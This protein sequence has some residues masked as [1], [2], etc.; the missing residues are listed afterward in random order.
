MNV[1]EYANLKG[2]WLTEVF[3]FKLFFRSFP[4]HFALRFCKSSIFQSAHIR[5]SAKG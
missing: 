1:Q 5:I 2:S 3:H 4:K